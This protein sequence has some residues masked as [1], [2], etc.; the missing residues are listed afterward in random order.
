MSKKVRISLMLTLLAGA[1]TG[2]DDGSNGNADAGTDASSSGDTAGGGGDGKDAGGGTL[3]ACG[4][5]ESEPNE[6]RDQATAYTVGNQVVACI[7]ADTDVDMFQ[8][9]SPGAVT[10]PAGGFFQVSLTNVGTGTLD[11]TVFTADDN[12]EILRNTYTTTDGQS[13]FFYWAAAP[14]KN[15]RFSV[16]RF[17]GFKAPYKYT[18]N[19]KYTKVPDM[20]EPNDTREQAKVLSLGTPVMPYIFAGHKTALVAKTDYD[21]F[22]EVKLAIG[23]VSVK[24]E[25][26]PLD[27]VPE[28]MLFNPSGERIGHQYNM[29]KGGS[30]TVASNISTAGTYRVSVGL[31]S[32]QPDEAAKAASATEVPSHF[33]KPYKLTVTQP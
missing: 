28:V 10:D 27:I 13:L 20:F 3:G 2:C 29:T 5:P 21:D 11:A 30:V 22:F 17:G 12:S 32:N 25:D 26:V 9:S 23:S 18:I 6:N 33:T 7:G 16:E 8:L 1:I 31:F 4:I 14:G 24:V 15:F 19:V